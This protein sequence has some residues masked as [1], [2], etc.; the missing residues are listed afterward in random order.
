MEE[1]VCA[2]VMTSLYDFYEYVNELLALC[3]S[4]A[5]YAAAA[6][7]AAAVNDLSATNFVVVAAVAAAAVFADG[8]CLMD[9]L[10]LEVI[11]CSRV[12]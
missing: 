3:V 4:R 7:A 6:A 10:S 9:A 12:G 1:L 2:L 5:Q 11:V 8:D